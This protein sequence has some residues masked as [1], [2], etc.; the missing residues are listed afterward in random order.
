MKF[1]HFEVSLICSIFHVQQCFD[2]PDL[3]LKQ[4]SLL[5]LVDV[6]I[7]RKMGIH[8]AH[9][10][11]V[12]FGDTSNH[13]LNDRANGTETGDRFPCAMVHLN[14]DCVALWVLER[15]CEMVEVL[16][17]LAYY[18]IGS[19]GGPYGVLCTIL[20]GSIFSKGVLMLPYL[21]DLLP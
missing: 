13:V 6:H 20:H 14:A 4:T 5:V 3:N 11:L 9:L 10:V 19:T 8:V 15:Y 12:A 2:A 17:E 18:V 1:L 21:V 16:D 7:D